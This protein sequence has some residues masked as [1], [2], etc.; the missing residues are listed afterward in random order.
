MISA[1]SIVLVSATSNLA[2]SDNGATRN[3]GSDYT[4]RDSSRAWFEPVNEDGAAPG[5]ATGY[6]LYDA[7][8]SD[9]AACL[10]GSAPLYYHR[11]G[12]GSGINK[13]Y[14]HHE[15]GGW[16]YDLG[17]CEGRAHT[18]LGSTTPSVSKD[19]NTSNLGGGYFDTDPTVNPQM[20]N[21]NAVFLRYCDGGSFSGNNLTSTPTASLP[22]KQMWF[23]G[24]HIL[25][26]MQTD[27]LTNRGLATSTDVVISGCSAG[28]L[29]TFLH[30]DNWA[31]LLTTAAPKAKVRGMPDSGF[32]L[33]TEHQPMYHSN[34]QWVFNYMNSTSGVND[35]CIAA[36]VGMEWKCIFAEHTS[37]HIKTPI[38]PLQGEY[39]SWQMCCDLGAET[40]D[41]VTVPLINSWGANLTAL[42]HANL[43]SSGVAHGIFLD[44]CLHH[45]G[46][47]G[48]IL[49]DGMVQGPAFQKWYETGTDGVHIQGKT[50][51]CPNC[52]KPM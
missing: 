40:K 3:D 47:W 38:F 2:N 44:S 24:K 42:V 12:T 48:Q 33:D 35:A 11:P 25:K 36:N 8:K 30:V 21:W 20:Y 29:A 17:S 37:P 46:A 5:V 4:R 22:E 14:I 31:D 28:G 7:L 34:M 13:W 49:I 16:C 51:P 43:L 6:W 50:Y 26:A 32:F 15:G 45:C 18:A 23:R 52:C 1:L 10:D 9:N 41:N 27:L 39:D 19:G